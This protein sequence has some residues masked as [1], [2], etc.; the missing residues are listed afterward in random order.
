MAVDARG[1]LEDGLLT[2]PQIKARALHITLLLAAANAIAITLLLVVGQSYPPLVPAGVLALSFGLRHAVDADHIAAIDNVTRRLIAD[3]RQPLL[4]G[5]WFSLGHSSEHFKAAKGVGELVSQIVSAV[6]LFAIG[7]ANLISLSGS[8]AQTRSGEGAG[9]HSHG[10]LFVRCC[11]GLLK[12]IDSEWKMLLLGFLFGLGFETSSEIALLALAGMSPSQGIPPAATLLL[13]LL[14][15]TGMSL[16]D[17]LDGLLMSWAYGFAAKGGSGSGISAGRRRL[18][19]LYLTATSSLIALVVGAL[20]VLGCV[21]KAR[22]LEG[23]FWLAVKDINDKFEYVGYAII[24][25]FAV[26]TLAA[27]TLFTCPVACGHLS[28]KGASGSGCQGDY[29]RAEGA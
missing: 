14:F 23:P 26:S 7:T 4:T 25:F 29:V 9:E 19:N 18:F 1:L 3:G 28:E 11:G 17:T 10:G 6:V 15:A 2:A 27:L 12:T 8:C 13:P 20:E 22:H 24:A 21:Q 5:L 16:V